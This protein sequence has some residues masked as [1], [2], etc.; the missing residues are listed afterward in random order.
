MVN[1]GGQGTWREYFTLPNILK[2]F[3]PKLVGYSLGDG[4]GHQRVT[5]FN[6]AE[7]GAMSRDLPHMARELVKRMKNDPRV[8]IEN[9]WKVYYVL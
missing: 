3:N 5:Q 8:D 6:T 4:L 1:S 2:E 9:D 7:I